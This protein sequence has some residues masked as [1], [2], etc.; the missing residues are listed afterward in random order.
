MRHTTSQVPG[1]VDA[2]AMRTT[3][4]RREG[5]GSGKGVNLSARQACVLTAT[6]QL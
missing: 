6:F 2:A 1:D 5:G 4:L 3:F